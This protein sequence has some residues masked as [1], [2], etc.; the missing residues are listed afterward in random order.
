[1]AKTGGLHHKMVGL[2]VAALAGAG[3]TVPG[4]P[5]RAADGLAPI[6]SFLAAGVATVGPAGVL[7]VVVS[8][9]RVAPPALE[10]RLARLGTWSWA[11]RHLPAAAVRLPAGRLDALRRLDGVRGV[12]A[13]RRLRYALEDSARLLDAAR[14]WNDLKV[15]G[16]GVTVAVLDTG[17][18]FTH[19]DLAP[20]LVANVKLV[21]FGSFTPVVPVEGVADSDTTSGHGTHVAGDVAGRGSASHG[22]F[23]GVAPGA[24]LVGIGAGEAISIFDALE[25]FDWILAHHDADHIK[26]VTN[27]WGTEFSPF[28]PANPIHVATKKLTDAGIT[29]LFAM[30]NNSDEM[31]M[32]PYAMAPWVIPVAAG[33][34][35]G[36][37]TGFSSGGIEA[38][39]LETAFG[40]A[41]VHGDPR[42]PGQLGLYHPAVTAP[43][44][45]IVS[46]RARTT[47]VP[48]MGARKDPT[49]LA[50][51]EVPFYTTMSGTSMATPETAGIVALVLEGDPALRP[52]QVRTI[53]QVTA[54]PIPGVPFEKQGYGY[55]D[56][57]AAVDLALA[58][59]DHPPEEVEAT[60]AERQTQRDR[61][62]LAGL[63]HPDRTWAFH[64]QVQGAPA[65][66]SHPL[67]VPAGTRRLK[68][69]FKAP[70]TSPII[71]PGPPW[72][73]SVT[74]AD[75]RLVDGAVASSSAS[76]AA[77]LDLGLRG[78]QPA[79][80]R[81]T[82]RVRNP[83]STPL[84][85]PASGPLLDD[86]FPVALVAALFR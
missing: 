52:S 55:A 34:K 32:N 53:L 10:R 85:V 9:D 13:Q 51:D 23:R 12:F 56:A 67:D 2:V 81:W 78:T 49:H 48:L 40:D 41:D 8:L 47:V 7:D 62:V 60:L 14:A 1:M 84:R 28:S 86:V 27:S 4:F 35:A 45:D 36:R 26:V 44:E 80:G 61:T 38:D 17:V 15:T 22:R 54:R 71:D 65:E 68:V 16:K 77:V 37:V 42:R 74:D 29:V 19:P 30:G 50:P 75:G 3:L 43:G 5:A 79:F 25:G 72:L 21:G 57:S 20:A 39:T 31:T 64:D 59:R 76:G 69:V 73:L 24:G 33:T 70:T 58:L 6:D 82:V 11:F 63:D 66:L 18:D 83:G 46:T